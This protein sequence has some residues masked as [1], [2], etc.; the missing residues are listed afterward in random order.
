MYNYPLIFRVRQ[1][2][3]RPVTKDIGGEVES[4]LSS[5]LLHK[6]IGP[7]E[8][9]AI[10]A[11]SRGIG[12]IHIITRAIV[13]HIKRL[14]AKPFIV[15]AMGSHGNGRAEEQRKII[16]S[17]GI[18]ESFC[19]CPIRS[20]ME[21]VIVSTAKERFP[22]HFDRYAYEADHVIVCGRVRP[23][24]EFAGDIQSGLMKML[25]IGL[26]K[27]EGAKVYH[28]A[29]ID[30]SFGQ[31]VRSVAHEVTD[32]C[33]V[34]AG[35]AIV[36][37]AYHELAKISAIV[38]T[39]FEVREKELLVLA[40]RLMPKLPFHIADLLLIDEIGKN[41]AGSCADTNVTGRKYHPHCAR[42]DEYPKVRLI[43]VRELTSESHGNATAIGRTEFCLS[44]VIEKIDVEK[45][46]VNSITGGHPDNAMLP[47]DYPTDRGLLDAA[48]PL[49][50]LTPLSTAKLLW[51]RN[52]LDLSEVECSAAYLQQAEQCDDIEILTDLRPMPFNGRGMLPDMKQ[53][54]TSHY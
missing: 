48:L 3:E 11:G 42:E 8:T 27:H 40:K 17:Y 4:Q 34:V 53:L 21:T 38:P 12:K 6:K 30:Y 33:G 44:R 2:F 15:P 24:P 49:T 26:G 1:S 35:L 36:E 19:G 7:D 54:L 5:L 13:D 50:G 22:V 31:I 23:H 51:I 14:D 32:R 29:I 28:R 47:L 16:E 10:T 37:N 25:L 9:V 18:T 52:T 43:G 41:I 46:R 45:T 20:S 39:E